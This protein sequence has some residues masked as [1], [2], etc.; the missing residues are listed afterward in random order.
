MILINFVVG[1]IYKL[2]NVCYICDIFVYIYVFMNSIEMKIV[3]YEK[4]NLYKGIEL[5][6]VFS[7]Y[8][9]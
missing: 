2:I 5:E 4:N 9:G 3:L 1:I 8:F 6:Q 7:V